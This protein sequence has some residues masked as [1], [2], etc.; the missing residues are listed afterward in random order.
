VHLATWLAHTVPGLPQESLVHDERIS[1][2]NPDDARPI[3]H[4]PMDLPGH[5][6]LRHSLGSNPESL[7]AQ[8]ALRCSALDNC[9]TREATIVGFCITALSV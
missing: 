7:V 3:V 8:L 4:R 2:P 9:P 1:L 6:Q 5:S